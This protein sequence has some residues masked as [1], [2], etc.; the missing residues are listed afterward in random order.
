[1]RRLLCD[2]KE[3]EV[4]MSRETLSSAS[5]HGKLEWQGRTLP[6]SLQRKPGPAGTLLSEFWPPELADNYFYC[7]R[8]PGLWY[9]LYHSWKWSHS[10]PKFYLAFFPTKCLHVFHPLATHF[11]LSFLRLMPCH[12]PAHSCS[13]VPT[14]AFLPD[15]PLS[16]LQRSL[17][18]RTWLLS[19]PLLR[20]HN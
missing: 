2:D 4:S 19:G 7:F 14:Q 16:Q 18:K 20:N 1:M 12:L 9:F 11:P 15:P 5:T 8:P 17:Q 10:A 13:P 3:T 6:Q